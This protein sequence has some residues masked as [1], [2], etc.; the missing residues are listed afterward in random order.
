MLCLFGLVKGLMFCYSACSC[1]QNIGFIVCFVY[2]VC[3]L[4]MHNTEITEWI[5]GAK[6]GPYKPYVIVMAC[7]CV[8]RHHCIPKQLHRKKK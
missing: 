5:T 3:Q 2:V 8:C 1:S 7:V 4:Q 6:A